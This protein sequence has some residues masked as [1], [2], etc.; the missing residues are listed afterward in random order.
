MLLA[1]KIPYIG[2]AILLVILA[3]IPFV[4]AQNEDQSGGSGLLVSPTRTEIS[5]Q[6][7][8]QKS[9]TVTIRNITTNSLTAQAFINDFESDNVSGTPQIITDESQR[10]PYTIANMLSGLKDLQLKP[11]EIKEVN[12]TIDVPAN[13]APG[14]YFGAVRYAAVPEGTNTS[15][16]QVSLTA[17]VAHLVFV[18]VP[19]DITEQIQLESLK[20]QRNNEQGSFF[21]SKPDSMALGVKNLGNGF[22]RPFGNVTVK[23]IFGGEVHRYD[24]NNTDPKGIVL[25]QSSRTFVDPLS[26]VNLPGRYTATAAV[27]YGN[28]GEVVTFKSSFWYIPIWL[29]IVLV[30]ALAAAI[31]Y[32]RRFYKGRF[33]SSTAK[34]RKKNK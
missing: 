5:A 8:E 17:S 6:P 26:G 24:V 9:F 30:V 7:G 15:D 27:A 16:R 23:N 34:R 13:A 12:L 3:L 31:F 18:E 11:D 14:A 10:T 1:K 25:P 20:A 32:G 2:G 21:V 28:G 19:G 33:G 22:S 4:S 29:I